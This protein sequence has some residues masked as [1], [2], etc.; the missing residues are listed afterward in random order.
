MTE[1]KEKKLKNLIG[2]HSVNKTDNY[3]REG[4]RGGNPKE[5]T[6]QIKK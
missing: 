2:F 6:E 1:K 5:S 3:N 4:K